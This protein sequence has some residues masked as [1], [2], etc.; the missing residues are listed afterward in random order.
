M[1]FI[2]KAVVAILAVLGVC[3]IGFQVYRYFYT[4]IKTE[5]AYNYTVSDSMEASGVAV[6]S[7]TVIEQTYDG[8]INYNYQDGEKVSKGNQIAE[9]YSSEQSAAAK[10][11][12]SLLEQERTALTDAQTQTQAN[13]VHV[14][15]LNNQILNAATELS[16]LLAENDF[17]SLQE[18]ESVLISLINKKQ[19][20]TDQNTNFT[21][22]I[23]AINS[24]ISSLQS[25]LDTNTTLITAPLSGYFVGKVDGYEQILTP[26][27][28]GSLSVSQIEEILTAGNSAIS[29]QNY[30]GKVL[31]DFEWYFAAVVEKKDLSKFREGAS[32]TV[33]FP[34]AG[35]SDIPFTV[36]SVKEDGEKG[37]V[38][39][40]CDYVTAELTSLRGQTAQ[41]NFST[42]T[43]LLVNSKAVRFEDGVQGVYVKQGSQIKF[44]KLDIIYEGDG[45]V[46]SRANEADGELLQSHE[47]VVVEGRDLYDG[48][49]IGS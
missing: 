46:I 31:N 1:K 24:E 18:K 16:N 26:K 23:E 38:I 40:H 39:L 11:K 30:V 8:V 37:V 28:L 15:G 29:Q 7:E 32:L 45:F 47:E 49:P 41:L 12:I 17:S 42:Y 19:L 33:N 22:R 43:G 14:D 13:S 9:V 34:F 48:K 10:Y 35:V 25:S 44:R 5:V 6:R 20:L 27:N 21:S 3:L 4:D 36:F 2:I